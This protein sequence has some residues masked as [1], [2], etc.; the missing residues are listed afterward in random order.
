MF[1]WR[2]REGSLNSKPRMAL[3]LSVTFLVLFA[4]GGQKAHADEASEWLGVYRDPENGLIKLDLSI[5]ADNSYSLHYGVPR[6]WRMELEELMETTEQILLKVKETSGG[7]C[8]DRYQ[9][10][11]TINKD[12]ATAW[13]ATIEKS[14]I[15]FRESYQLLKE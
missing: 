3:A 12:S 6:S 4:P 11:I 9:A 1:N 15:D 13:T 8:D 10:D 5:G 2:T 7:F 14:A